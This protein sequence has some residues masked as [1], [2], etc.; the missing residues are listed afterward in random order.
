V[1]RADTPLHVAVD[2][3]PLLGARTGVGVF[4]HALLRGLGSRDDVDVT[5]F[6][7]SVSGRGHL[8]DA[9]PPGVDARTP[10][11]PARPLH[12]VWRRASLPRLDALLGRPDVVH[13]P[14]FVVPPARAARV[15]TV[16]DLTTLRFPELCHPATLAFPSLVRRAAAE[17]AWVH[18]PSH[19]V[20]DEVLAELHLDPDRVV[21]VPNGFDLPTG[22][23]DVGRRLAG[24]ERYVLAVGTVEPRKDLPSLVRAVDRLADEHPDLV[25]VHAG[26]DGWGVEDLEAATAS[27]RRPERFRRLGHVAHPELGHLYAGASVF[28]YPSVYEGFGIPVLEAMASGVPVVCTDV[29]AVTEVAG[30]AAAIVPVGDVDALAE[31]IARAW[32]D[33]AWRAAAIERG[34]ARTERYSWDACVDGLVGVYRSALAGSGRA[35]HPA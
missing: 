30:D 23:A 15:A 17:G 6:P 11:L 16:H 18:T 14:N 9:L 13:G 12:A 33:D 10:P 3:T 7:I 29:P 19:A 20:R 22:D 24:T 34:H 21:A 31:A 4:T 26:G 28:A 5:A 25:L 8:R 2:A 1:P 35:R 27:L 32:T